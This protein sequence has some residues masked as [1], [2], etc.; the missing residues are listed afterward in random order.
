MK[1]SMMLK[2]GEFARIGN[3]SI[4]TL[5]HYAQYGLLKPHMLDPETGYRYYSLDQLPRLHRILALKDLG[6][7]LEQ[8]AQLLEEDL[9]LGQLQAL[10]RHKQV[11]LRQMIDAEEERLA[12]VATRL[13][14]IEQEGNMPAYDILLKQVDP[15]P[16]ASVRASIPS[17]ADIGRLREQLVA[18]LHQNNMQQ[19][20]TDMIIWHTRHEMRDAEMSVDVEAAIPLQVALPTGHE[21]VNIRTLPAGLM[22][23]TVHTGYALSLGLAYIALHRWVEENG[24]RHAGPLRQIRLQHGEHLEANQYVTELQF[25][26]EKLPVS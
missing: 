23:C 17:I 2:I 10:F 8:I 3:V 4:V 16:V 13:R 26:V 21:P 5:R 24:Y 25:P 22:A 11:Q 18:Y 15:L 9:S 7:P 20:A 6:F 12:R 1:K 14:Q 19:S